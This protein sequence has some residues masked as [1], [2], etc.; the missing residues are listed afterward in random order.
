MPDNFRSVL[1]NGGGAFK[2]TARDETVV[3]RPDAQ[4]FQDFSLSQEGGRD[5]VIIDLGRGMK[6]QGVRLDGGNAYDVLEIRGLGEQALTTTKLDS[7]TMRITSAD[8]RL[9]ITV[10]SYEGLY[11]NNHWLTNPM[12]VQPARTR[13][14][15]S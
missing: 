7:N 10:S 11:N 1:T 3:L 2:G 13:T 9:D 5:R 6:L 12:A 15:F 14:R 4:G 8:G